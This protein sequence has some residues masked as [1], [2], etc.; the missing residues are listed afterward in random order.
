MNIFTNEEI[1]DIINI[2][3]ETKDIDLLIDKYHTSERYLRQVL[4]ENKIDRHY[5]YVS[6]E[7]QKRIGILYLKGLNQRQISEEVFIS[8]SA[9][10]K[11]LKEQNIPMRST[12]ECNMRYKRNKH[13]FDEINTP[14]K[15]YILGLLYADGCNH[16]LHNS[17]T[18][19]LQ[20][21]DVQVIE[22]VKQE[23][24][25]EGNIRFSAKDKPQYKDKYILCINDEY[26]SNQLNKIGMVDNKSLI[27]EFPK[28]VPMNLINHFVRGYFDGDG[29]IYLNKEIRKT[30]ICIA[31][32]L[33]MI[34]RIHDIAV[35]MNCPCSICHPKQC[36]ESNTYTLRINGYHNVKNFMNWMYDNADIKME[37]KYNKYLEVVKMFESTQNS[38]VA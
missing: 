10:R 29:C 28:C 36:G 24:E 37:R 21:E 13:Y 26:M 30:E 27:L 22:R 14:N 9:I 23:L 7:L 17:I 31:G 6:D 11:Y 5:G 34:K 12:S 18:L 35:L 3:K 15:A 32:T 25:Y 38:Q 4:K 16:I 20:A 8:D 1:Q 33:D 19:T 2:Y